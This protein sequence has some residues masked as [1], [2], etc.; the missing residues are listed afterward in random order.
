MLLEAKIVCREPSWFK[1]VA[2]VE[3]HEKVNLFFDG[4]LDRNDRRLYEVCKVNIE[5]LREWISKKPGFTYFSN[6]YWYLFVKPYCEFRGDGLDFKLQ[7]YQYLVLKFTHD[8]KQKFA[9]GIFKIDNYALSITQNIPIPL[10]LLENLTEN[11]FEAAGFQVVELTPEHLTY[12]LKSNIK[13][14]I[15]KKLVEWVQ[16]TLKPNPV[17]RLKELGFID[18]LTYE[19]LKSKIGFTRFSGEVANILGMPYPTY[20]WLVFWVVC[21]KRAL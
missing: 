7:P 12:Q 2:D 8:G 4:F 6:A 18:G 5:K 20:F 9:V 3:K 16:A 13:L 14:R 17:K 19:I 1:A 15:P 11:K 10:S 21:W